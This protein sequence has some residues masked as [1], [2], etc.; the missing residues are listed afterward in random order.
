MGNE[1][2]GIW[3][4]HGKISLKFR[5]IYFSLV[6]YIYSILESIIIHLVRF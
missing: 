1:G 3:G 4:S 5:I 2:F 6:I